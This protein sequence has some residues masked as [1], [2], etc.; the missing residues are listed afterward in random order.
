LEFLKKEIAITAPTGIA[1]VN[2]GGTT[3]HS[4][5]GIGTFGDTF[6]PEDLVK[7]ILKQKKQT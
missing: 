5:S 6:P 3:I 7:K 2:V 4:F 1:A